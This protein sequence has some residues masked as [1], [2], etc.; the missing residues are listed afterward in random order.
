L[1]RLPHRQRQIAMTLATGETTKATAK[2]FAV[3]PARISQF[4]SEFRTSWFA[5]HGEVSAATDGN[6]V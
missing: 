5:F 2:R 4:R 1:R 3:S 6:A